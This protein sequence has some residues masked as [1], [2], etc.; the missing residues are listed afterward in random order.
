VEPAPAKTPSPKRTQDAPQSEFERRCQGA[1]AERLARLADEAR[2][3]REFTDEAF[4]LRLLRRRFAGTPPGALAA[5]ALGRLEFDV[6]GN[7][8]RAAEW[9]GTY[10]KEQPS[11]PLAREA[12]GRLM[13]ATLKAGELQRARALAQDYLEAYPGG[14]HAELARS[15]HGPGA[16][17]P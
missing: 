1:S 10:L 2:Y 17:S 9:F 13:E 14:P 6:H 4:A 5:F 3:A 12:R 11:G 7:H 8:R 16:P 15:L